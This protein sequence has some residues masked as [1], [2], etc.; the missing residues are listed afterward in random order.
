MD[1][2]IIDFN[3]SVYDICTAHPEIKD[4]LISAGLSNLANPVMFST[5][6]RF[7]KIP[8]GAK[9]HNIDVS[10]IEQKIRDLGF[11]IKK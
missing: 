6:A 9:N 4:V 1:S 2:K 11:E 7:A 3:E 5:A 8:E 10:V